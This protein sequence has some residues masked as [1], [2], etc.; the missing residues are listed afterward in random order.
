MRRDVIVVDDFYADPAAVVRH[1]RGLEYVYP[2]AQPG[3]DREGCPRTW[4]ASRYRSANEC[5]FKSSAALISRLQALTGELVDVAAWRMEFP[6]D[7]NGY[8]R[9]DHRLVHPKSAWWNCCF[10]LKLDVKQELGGGVH[11][12]TDH[13]SWNP[14]GLDGWA[15]LVYLNPAPP[16]NQGG[17]RTWDNRDP[18]RQFEWMTSKHNWQLRDT[19]ANVYNRLILHR[20]R[21]PHSGSNGWGD[22]FE[23][24][25]FFQTF[26]FRTLGQRELPSLDLEELNF[27]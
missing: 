17:L 9:S 1:A 20:G 19:F 18:A 16:T 12:H 14:V 10:H 11:S 2:Y 6:I 26:F 15:G 7:E 25:R 5:P 22:S 3:T 13:D 8:P 21:V 4:F 23:N 24:G 27:G